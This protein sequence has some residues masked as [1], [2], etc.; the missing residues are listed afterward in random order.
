MMRHAACEKMKGYS[1]LFILNL[2]IYINIVITQ[3]I[4]SSQ[5]LETTARKMTA[6]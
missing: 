1:R 6:R 5:D 2:F 4:I 3:T